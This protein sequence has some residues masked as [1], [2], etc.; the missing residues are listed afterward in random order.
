MAYGLHWNW[1]LPPF[2]VDVIVVFD[3]SN[4]VPFIEMCIHYV[5]LFFF[6]SL[7]IEIFKPI[8]LL[9]IDEIVLAI[10]TMKTTR[11]SI[12]SQE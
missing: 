6:P 9:V 7:C 1:K 11:H 5:V 8:G 2:S 10:G 3:F 4:V 12:Q